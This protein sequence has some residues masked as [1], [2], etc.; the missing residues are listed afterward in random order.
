MGFYG[1]PKGRDFRIVHVFPSKIDLDNAC[2]SWPESVE[3]AVGDYYMIDY[4]LP[5]DNNATTI[6]GQSFHGSLW[7]VCSLVDTDGV[8]TSPNIYIKNTTLQMKIINYGFVP[9]DITLSAGNASNY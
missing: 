7:Q 3:L 8:I 4:N 5:S 6:N 1:G 2:A 9:G